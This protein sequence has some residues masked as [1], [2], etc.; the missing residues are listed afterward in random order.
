MI[1]NFQSQQ[2]ANPIEQAQLKLKMHQ[3][4]GTSSQLS[5]FEVASLMDTIVFKQAINNSSNGTFQICFN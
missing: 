3:E 4:K 5:I 1:Y 2:I